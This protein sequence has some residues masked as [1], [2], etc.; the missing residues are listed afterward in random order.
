MSNSNPGATPNCNLC[1]G[2]CSHV[3]SPIGSRVRLELYICQ[4]CGFLQTTK[5]SES[6]RKNDAT[7]RGLSCDADY[8]NVRV[9][10]R[11]MLD[12][13][14]TLLE[15][16][17]KLI[18]PEPRILD[19]AA[20][21]GDFLRH[22]RTWKPSQLVGFEPDEYMVKDS[23]VL[24]FAQLKFGDYR[25]MSREQEFDFIYSCH[26][27]EHFSNPS[28]YFDFVTSILSPN[29][30]FFVDV[31]N[32]HEADKGLV[33]DEYFYDNHR[34]YFDSSN[35]DQLAANFGLKTV[36]GRNEG[37]SLVRAF[38]FSQQ[39]MPKAES[40]YQLNLKLI[41][42]YQ[43]KMAQSRTRIHD[44]V[45]RIC[46]EVAVHEGPTI[47][48][49][50]G[51][52]TDAL[53][54]YGGIN[55]NIFGQVVDNYLGQASSKV[56]GREIKVFEELETLKNPL[57]VVSTKSSTSSIF[58]SIRSKYPNAKVILLVDLFGAEA[59]S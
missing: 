10:K 28:D 39:R 5:S 25:S 51:R 47:L 16:A 31:P 50:A 55:L 57:F 2:L 19:M 36:L 49:G 53:V 4:N 22:A 43:L 6:I 11:Q 37:S 48:F 29:G 44:V 52:A 35:L 1:G 33:L 15:K 40:R 18:N 26:S 45:K 41:N 46:R 42:N 24:Q 14:K 56:L 20:G 12:N 21:R 59:I 8:S 34:V 27:L 17:L 7:F 13:T 54:K 38:K 30:V 32:V 58:A 3:Y 23:P 9:G